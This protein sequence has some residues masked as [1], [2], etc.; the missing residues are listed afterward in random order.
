VRP[1]AVLLAVAA[2]ILSSCQAG[3]RW[4][5]ADAGPA[6][7]TPAA[8][9]GT[10]LRL[11]TRAEYGRTVRD[12]LGTSLTPEAD[13][14]PEALS[15]GLDNTAALNQATA[16]GVSRY[17]LAAEALA[18]D[19]LANHRDRVLPCS[20]RD[21]ACA[22]RAISDF[23]LRAWRRPLRDEERLALTTLA[24]TTSAASGFD[25]GL[26][27]ALEAMLQ[28]PQF[29]YRD[30]APLAPLP[31]PVARLD[32]YQLA[33]RL[34]YFLWGTTP[35]DELLTAAGQ[36]VLDTPEGL[37]A[38]ARRLLLDPRGHE[39]LL[40]SLSLLLNL[41]AV[42]QVEKSAAAY[43]GWSHAL[44]GAW[45]TSLELYLRD[46]LAHE[47]TV[48]ALL[49]TNLLYTD[50]SMGAYGASP[51]ASGFLRTVP[52][53][54][55]RRGLL[56]QP[57]F[58]AQRAMPDMSSPVRR[59]VFVL[60]L[61]CQPPPPPP[62]G[63]IIT[64]PTHSTVETTRERF[65]AHSDNPACA[66][67]H[68]FIDPPGF[69]FEHYDGVGQWRDTENGHPIDATGGLV[70]ARDEALLAPVDGLDA[71]EEALAG[72][73]QVHDCLARGVYQF[74]LGRELTPADE[75]TLAQVS[76]RFWTSGGSFQGLLEAIV[77][78]PSFRGNL[79]PELAP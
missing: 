17:L 69:A 49:R 52:A 13:F 65:A 71:L 18:A 68:R 46:V 35:D 22:A 1:S 6:A 64:P 41:D 5:P 39:G 79:E 25:T 33:T 66:S 72:S 4:D 20:T 77:A 62:A 40:R 34:A 45:R 27:V 37:A 8:T 38:Q 75:C 57:G 50:A 30:E 58:L 59:G 9:P 74:A 61:A 47:G 29:L 36:G 60:T 2:G 51:T 24:G 54:T 12:L 48:R 70:T 76:E 67:C 3:I 10:S 7:C 28:A 55:R 19:A 31:V 32:G 63:L 56:A 73:R 53:G 78:S 15:R 14:P 16:E 42:P 21:D 23:G 44:S 11:L 26:A 43:P